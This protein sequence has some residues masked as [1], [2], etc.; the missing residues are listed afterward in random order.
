MEDIGGYVFGCSL[1]GPKLAPKISPNKT[2]AG[3]L[4]GIFLA[5]V[6]S[7]GICW[8][9]DAGAVVNAYITMA[10]ALAVIAQ[11]GDLIESAIKRHLGLK[12]SSNII[13]GHGGI[14]DRVDGLIFA[15]PFA[16]LILRNLVL[17]FE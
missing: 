4:G 3:L 7:Y 8:Y 11:I 12:D 13:P 16:L 6:I 17:F 14:F 9:F 5:V 15:A 2:W 10:A 1:K